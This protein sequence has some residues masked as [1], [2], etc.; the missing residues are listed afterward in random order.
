MPNPED[1]LLPAAATDALKA[2][3]SKLEAAGY[4]PDE[5]DGIVLGA[6]EDVMARLAADPAVEGDDLVRTIERFGDLDLPPEQP[7]P[8]PLVDHQQAESG[9]L[10]LGIGA[11][12]AMVLFGVV[13]VPTDGETGGALMILAALILAP[14]ALWMGWRARQAPAGRAGFLLGGL[15]ISVVLISIGLNMLG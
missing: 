14:V 9:R 2:L 3:R 15:T 6:Q 8:E 10:A 13:I 12:G 7:A 5:T 4:A 1:V 11:V